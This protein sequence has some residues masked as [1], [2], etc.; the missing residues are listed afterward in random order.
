M[1]G[2]IGTDAD[3]AAAAIIACYAVR[4][5]WF[6]LLAFVGNHIRSLER[7]ENAKQIFTALGL[8]DVPVGMGE[9][10]FG[11]SSVLSE[12]DPRYLAHPTKIGHGRT[13]LK[14]T[15]EHSEDNSVVLVLNSGFTDAV[16]LWMD[17]P[18]L[19]LRKVCRVVIMGGIE[20]DGDL[21]KLSAEGFLV[22]NI[23]KGG[24]A[25]NNFD[26]GATLHIYDAMQRHGVPMIVTTRFAAYGC[27]MPYSIFEAM[28]ATGSPIGARIN[29]QQATR[30]RELWT[31]ANADIGS[32]ERGDLPARCDRNWF[33]NT[34]CD[35]RDPGE[36]DVLLYMA[37]VAWY[38]PMNLIASS[39]ELRARF[40]QPYRIE[41]K[42]T[43]HL[44]I[45]LTAQDHGVA[46]PDGLRGFMSH[47]V[48]G[49]LSLGQTPIPVF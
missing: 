31:K 14:W 39:D 15:L 44:V 43:T 28:G 12:D 40:F 22:P 26:P 13:V 20:M 5:G 25:N 21:P 47:S 41:V 27:K 7:A 29:E 2:E 4:E 42:G 8:G 16:W 46:D 33:V 34:F 45:G 1:V 6:E 37:E 23:G 11:S 36:D 9:R 49:A 35:G 48:T 38:D 19:F 30:L 3:E 32:F 18:G 17:D 10:G 24:A